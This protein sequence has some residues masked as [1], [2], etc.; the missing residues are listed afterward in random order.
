MFNL[1]SFSVLLCS[2]FLSYFYTW[3]GYNEKLTALQREHEKLREKLDS[4]AIQMGPKY[5]Y[6]FK[7]YPEWGRQNLTTEN[8]RIG[9]ANKKSKEW[10]GELK[11]AF[12]PGGAKDQFDNLLEYIKKKQHQ[13]YLT[14][15]A[16]E[17]VKESDLNSFWTSA[18]R[19]E[20]NM[21]S[22]SDNMEERTLMF[23]AITEKIKDLHKAFGNEEGE[24]SL[25]FGSFGELTKLADKLE[26]VK[27]EPELFADFL[28]RF[29]AEIT[30][31]QIS[32]GR[33]TKISKNI[34]KAQEATVTQAM[35]YSE[36][37]KKVERLKNMI[38]STNSEITEKTH[39]PIVEIF[40]RLHKSGNELM[41]E[42]DELEKFNHVWMKEEFDA[43]Q[44]VIK[45]GSDLV[46]DEIQNSEGLSFR[47]LILKSHLERYERGF[48]G[49][50]YQAVNNAYEVMLACDKFLK[51]R[52]DELER[53]LTDDGA[54][55]FKKEA[56][57]ETGELGRLL[58]TVSRA[59]ADLEWIK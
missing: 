47:L 54:K 50:R 33:L 7:E 32:F 24:L 39:Q 10:L 46:I 8:S 5:T 23:N 12:K 9:A 13:N 44:N 40:N 3:S 26:E 28:K 56:F 25:K 42:A 11:E 51:E 6:I 1:A 59:A 57:K 36:G 29:D 19:N 52:L 41:A 27:E 49:N 4:Y 31:M 22:I 30:A 14:E 43:L 18:A 17:Q 38:I 21:N 20:I 34:S 2:I 58:K 53:L 55:Q 45:P 35:E 16:V 37:L 15:N 48:D